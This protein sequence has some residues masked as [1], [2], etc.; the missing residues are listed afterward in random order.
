MGVKTAERDVVLNVKLAYFGAVAAQEQLRVAEETVASYR[1]HL[2]QITAFHASG[3]R[4]GIDVA[5]AEAALA[6][7]QL[8]LARSTASLRRRRSSS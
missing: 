4:T 8:Q 6:G 5:T 2:V 3:L 7:A 1:A